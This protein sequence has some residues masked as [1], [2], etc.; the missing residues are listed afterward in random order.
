M[1]AYIS[2]LRVLS[3]TLDS[4]GRLGLVRV[5]LKLRQ[6]CGLLDLRTDNTRTRQPPPQTRLISRLP[7]RANDLKLGL[8]LGK[9]KLY[10]L[11][12]FECRGK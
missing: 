1:A 7:V 2:M 10:D 8:K 9:S 4:W 12:F 3:P 11:K 6:A 5:A